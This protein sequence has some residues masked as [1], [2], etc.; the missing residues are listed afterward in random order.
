M[1][2]DGERM[3]GSIG[4][5]VEIGTRIPASPSKKCYSDSPWHFSN[6]QKA[7]IRLGARSLSSGG[8]MRHVDHYMIDRMGE[9]VDPEE[10]YQAMQKKGY[11]KDIKCLILSVT[12]RTSEQRSGTVPAAAY[13]IVRPYKPRGMDRSIRA[14]FIL[15]PLDYVEAA[16]FDETWIAS[17][18][19]Q[20]TRRNTRDAM[21]GKPRRRNDDDVW[22]I[23]DNFD[24]SAA[25][26]GAGMPISATPFQATRETEDPVTLED[27]AAFRALQELPGLAVE[28]EKLVA[29]TKEE[30]RNFTKN[31][32]SLEDAAY[33]DLV[34]TK[35]E[36][37]EFM[38]RFEELKAKVE[39]VL[40]TPFDEAAFDAAITHYQDAEYRQANMLLGSEKPPQETVL[41]VA[42]ADS[43][44]RTAEIIARAE[45]VSVD[46]EIA[47]HQLDAAVEAAAASKKF[48]HYQLNVL[49]QRALDPV[50]ILIQRALNPDTLFYEGDLQSA[51][52]TNTPVRDY[53]ADPIS[54][55]T[56]RQPKHF[57]TAKRPEDASIWDEGSASQVVYEK[58]VKDVSAPSSA[59]IVIASALELSPLET[60][61]DYLAEWLSKFRGKDFRAQ[62]LAWIK[63][64]NIDTVT[65]DP[66]NY[67]RDVY[68][69]LGKQM[70]VAMTVGDISKALPD[71]P[72]VIIREV[73]QEHRKLAG[74]LNFGGIGPT[75]VAGKTEKEIQALRRSI[76]I[77]PFVLDEVQAG[78]YRLRALPQNF[79]KHD[80]LASKAVSR[81]TRS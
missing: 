35:N 68:E 69:V 26:K 41:P 24:L 40:S 56:P 1:A 80:L 77:E 18:I 7:N 12:C 53:A 63:P 32:L 52:L 73:L 20:D 49:I 17:R 3:T 31:I 66:N 44:S 15:V 81:P 74:K 43:P 13:Q 2:A 76:E 6:D 55:T 9:F 38:A 60:P 57:K 27:I 16:V 50:N 36:T 23:F 64:E 5:D 75:K 22:N 42:P 59:P 62:T 8:I 19:Q 46:M 72:S 14:P 25:L 58:P 29:E 4:P 65:R 39:G 71:V 48:N 30:L 78:V 33:L 47:E 37:E 61:E 21:R 45:E 28:L 51:A 70:G 67:A 11:S 79:V 34:E 10:L 54:S